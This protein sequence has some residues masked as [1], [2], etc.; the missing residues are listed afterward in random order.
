[1]SSSR[2]RDIT[3]AERASYVNAFREIWEAIFNDHPNWGPDGRSFDIV[4]PFFDAIIRRVFEKKEN[5]CI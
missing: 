5:L 1:M 2:E 3:D 4:H